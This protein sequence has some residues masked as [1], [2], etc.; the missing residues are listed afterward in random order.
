MT[1]AGLK[2]HVMVNRL[3]YK[4]KKPLHNLQAILK[5]IVN[6]FLFHS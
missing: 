5:E 1:R 4:Y 3:S 2:T 6:N